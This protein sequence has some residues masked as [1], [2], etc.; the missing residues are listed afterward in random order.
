MNDDLPI[1]PAPPP[2]FTRPKALLPAGACDGHVHMVSDG[3]D[4][5][6]WSGRVET[7][8]P[9]DFDTWY[10]RFS[11]T[12]DR[13]GLGRTIFVHSILFGADNSVTLAAVR[14]MGRA[15]ARAVVLVPD[16][17]REQKLQEFRDQ[18]ASAVRLNYVHGGILSWQG[19]VQMAPDLAAQGMHIQMLLNTDAHMGQIADDIRAL[20]VPVV[21][22]HLGWPNVA[23][24]LD[25]PGFQTLLALMGEGHVYVKLSAPYRYDAAPF[26]M[27][28]KMMR[29]LLD[30]NAE[31]CLWGSDW[32]HLMLGPAAMPDTGQMLNTLIDVATP[33][34]L[35][36]VLV[37]N[38]ETLYGFDP[39]E[40]RAAQ[41]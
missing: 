12:Q 39:A 16:G 32:P 22:D 2:M 29:A 20:P 18:G 21:I 11:A 38:P 41:S 34:E 40:R 33:A 23:Q 37:T 35:D 13:L 7:P 9:G 28:L 19:A 25:E 27:S 1:A 17:T 4:F 3:T 30:A 24:G 6:L 10:A 14:R 5:A 36:Q 8:A 15:Q 31:R 26:S